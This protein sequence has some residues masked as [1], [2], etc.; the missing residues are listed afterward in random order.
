MVRLSRTSRRLIIIGA[1]LVAAIGS[2]VTWL[3]LVQHEAALTDTQ[4]AT[5]R[6]AQIL[7]EQTARTM[8][9]VDLTLRE[10]QG[11]LETGLP[12]LAPSSD[13]PASSAT[14]AL[15]AER[16]K[17]LPQVDA[18]IIIAANGQLANSSRSFPPPPLD[19]SNRE[20]YRY[21]KAHDDH[22]VF[23]TAPVQTYIRG[24]WTV[25]LAR[26]INGSDG[27]LSGIVAA[28]ITLSHL[29]DF[30]KAVT[31]ED[32]TVT[33]LRRDGTVLAH[34]PHDDRE[35]G[36]RLPKEA[37]WYMF[38]DG[39]GGSFRSPGYLNNVPRIVS[40]RPLHDFPLVINASTSESL[41]LASWRRQVFWLLAGAATAAAGV[42]F[43]L[44]IFGRQVSRLE[45][46]NGQLESGR[47]QFDAVLHNMSQGITFFD[48]NQ[49]LILSNRRY[50]EIYRLSSDQTR[51]GTLLRDILNLRIA[52]RSFPA[53]SQAEYLARRE[54]FSRFREPY[55]VIDELLDGRTIA[56]RYQPMPNGGWVATHEDITDRRR[57][58]AALLH[59]ARHD[60]MT[61]LPNRTLF[62][63][64]LVQ[65]IAATTRETHCAV[66]CFDLDGFKLVNDTLGHPVGDA[67]LRAV[68]ARLLGAVRDTDTVA[69]LGGDEFAII[70]AGLASS[71]QATILADRL[72]TL[73]R[74]PHNL[75]GH[76]VVVGVS[77]GI[78][79]APGDGAS[80]EMLLKKADIALYVAKTD[81]RGTFRFFEPD[82]DVR[83][84]GRRILELDLQNA[85]PAD[86]FGLQ[87]QPILELRSGDIIAFEA[88]IR[89]NHPERGLVDPGDFIPIAEDTGLILQI[90]EWA[91]RTACRAAADWPEDI[92]VTVN[93]SPV[94]FKGAHLLAVVRDALAASGLQPKR[95]VLEITES[96]LLESSDNRLTLLN[97]LRSLGIRIAL[98]DF[99]TGYS[100]LSYLRNFPFDIIKIDRSFIRDVDTNPDSKVILGAII[101]LARGLGMTTTAEGVETAQQLA[102]LDES[103]C[104]SVQ[105]YLFSRPLPVAEVAGWIRTSRNP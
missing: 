93:L 54:A 41:A 6:L 52:Y 15:L 33:L 75:D 3:I 55:D 74:Q 21:F 44:R 61:Q 53:M 39:A 96:V 92:C 28:A 63:E 98:D 23:V 70:Q 83:L 38:Q 65:A 22:A 19:L 60:A 72:I 51:T 67:L 9:P 24:T 35:I 12:A 88:L 86:E 31:P 89:W 57:A 59:M 18:L 102:A 14:Y 27:E 34:Y 85:L 105:G 99:G 16:L 80:P 81:A 26:R 62:H 95:L 87:Y 43:L 58:E 17:G 101:D 103:G 90:G 82:M 5:T 47:Q 104:N 36:W 69:R 94:Q 7:A 64:R 1:L 76:R 11:W 78:A 42:I 71:E 84:Q 56:M 25:Y 77:G 50:G 97:Q 37:P 2:T 49:K 100:S 20:I 73:M 4:Q 8:Q 68:A 48:E 13:A 40:V 45:R 32:G 91:L 30:Y 29:E 79:V 66:L 10:I 46:Q